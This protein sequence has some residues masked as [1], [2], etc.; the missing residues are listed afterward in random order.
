MPMKSIPEFQ[1]SFEANYSF[2]PESPL[3]LKNLTH[4]KY[5]WALRTWAMGLDPRLVEMRLSGPVH[6]STQK[7]ININ[8]QPT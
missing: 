7:N 5:N 3:Y 1:S 6:M 2:Q 4:Y 8:F